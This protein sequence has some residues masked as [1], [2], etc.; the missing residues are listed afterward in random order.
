MNRRH[1]LLA[2]VS[3][4]LGAVLPCRPN[5]EPGVELRACA[6]FDYPNDRWEPCRMFDLKEGDCFRLEE[7]GTFIAAANPILRPE[8][9]GVWSIT[10]SYTLDEKTNEWV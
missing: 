10:A 3:L 2:S 6:R 7:V 8:N 9:K 5:P 1:A 4:G